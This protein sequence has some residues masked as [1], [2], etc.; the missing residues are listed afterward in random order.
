MTSVPKP[1]K[2][3]KPHYETL[4]KHYE[5]VS[6]TDSE[7]KREFA[8]FLSVISM[9]MAERGKQISL[10]FLQAGTMNEFKN[11]GYE[12]L[13]HLSADIGQTYQQRVEKGEDKSDLMQLV[14]QIVPYFV[15]NNAEHDAVD[16][17]ME[18]DSLS[19]IQ[20]FV[21]VENYER[22]SLY[23]EQCSLYCVD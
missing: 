9:T 12:Y 22:I 15:E 3:L 2:F 20:K 10:R 7:Y 23:L 18:V 11:W 8:D 17:L 13:N 5:T 6:S 1:F 4:T 14:E 16:L 19:E 21:K